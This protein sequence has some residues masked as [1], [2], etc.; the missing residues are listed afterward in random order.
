M[1][2]INLALAAHVDS[3]KTTLAEQILFQTGTLLKAGDV[4][5]GSSRLDWTEIEKSGG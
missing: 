1:N 3:G 5:K 2:M 4:N